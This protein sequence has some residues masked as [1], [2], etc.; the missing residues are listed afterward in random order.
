MNNFYSNLN[1]LIPNNLLKSSKTESTSTMSS[2]KSYIMGNNSNSN[3]KSKSKTKT[4]SKNGNSI[5]KYIGEGVLK[6]ILVVLL[7]LL[8]AFLLYRLFSY[9]F[10]PARFLN[11]PD[12]EPVFICKP[13]NSSKKC[14][15]DGS[16]GSHN[17]TKPYFYKPVGKPESAR[18]FIPSDVLNKPDPI[19]HNYSVS[20]WMKVDSKNWYSRLGDDNET[21]LS[22][23]NGENSENQD[24]IEDQDTPTDDT[25]ST[26]TTSTDDTSTDALIIH[27]K[28]VNKM[29]NWS[30]VLYRGSKKK[31]VFGFWL[32]PISNTL[33]CHLHTKTR[34]EDSVDEGVLIPDIPINKWFNITAVIN[35]RSYELY[36]NGKLYKTISLYGDPYEASGN[37]KITSGGGFKGE[38]AYLQ[39]FNTPIDAKRIN[40]LYKYYLKEIIKCEKTSKP[41]PDPTPDPTPTP[42]PD[43]TPT[44]VCP[45]CIYN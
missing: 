9:L 33:S 37:M 21:E 13:C 27:K 23:F 18:S 38:L 16:Q 40:L 43:P 32:S 14:D 35:Q 41:C 11:D 20:F 2:I 30:S 7:I 22:G 45:T 39:Y 31:Q 24:V 28:N 17:A 42:T 12:T 1:Q 6:N 8:I 44:P 15:I 5:M 36:F 10:G 34:K 26:D 25:T 3:S 29:K 4:N 19:T